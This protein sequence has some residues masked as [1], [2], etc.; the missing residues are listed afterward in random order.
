M[1]HALSA[2]RARAAALLP[3]A[4]LLAMALTVREVLMVA[5]AASAATITNA[6]AIIRKIV[7]IIALALGG[8]EA[9]ARWP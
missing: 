2:I 6:K 4:T 8:I 5:T 9:A 7:S 3:L 1:N